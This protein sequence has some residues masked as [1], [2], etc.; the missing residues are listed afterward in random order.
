MDVAIWQVLAATGALLGAVVGAAVAPWLISLVPEGAASGRR[1]FLTRPAVVVVGAVVGLL[2]GAHVRASIEPL[3]WPSALVLLAA[4]AG[5]G[6]VDAAGHR[7]PDV[8]V[9]RGWA[10]GAVL[11]CAV[12]PWVGAARVLLGVAVSALCWAVLTA[13]T[14]AAPRAL[15][16][17][18]VKLLGLLALAVALLR[19]GAV[20]TA[21]VA[22]V[23]LGGVAALLLLVTR[24]AAAG[25]H[26]AF[27]PWLLAGAAVAILTA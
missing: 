10:V 11:A 8:L 1:W 21:V 22:A 2:A 26:L 6:L 16:Y 3:L 13:V 20:V 18:D 5:A 24:R 4:A 27:G 12:L 7:L 23:V 9:L 25:T 14:L 15:G 19:P 17:G